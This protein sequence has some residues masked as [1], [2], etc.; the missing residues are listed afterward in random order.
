MT[1]IPLFKVHMNDKVPE[2][3]GKVLMSGMITQ[4]QKVEEFESR[5]KEW[6]NYPYILLEHLIAVITP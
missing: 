6:F 2:M 3:V 1:T 4:G 5:L